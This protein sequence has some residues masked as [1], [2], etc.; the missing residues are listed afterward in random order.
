[1]T[2]KKLSGIA[3]SPGIVYGKVFLFDVQ[4]DNIV[5]THVAAAK[6]PFEIARLEEALIIT[7]REILDIQQRLSERLGVRHAEIFNA[8]LMVL[9]DRSLLEEVIKKLEKDQKNVEFVFNEVIQRYSEIFS[10]M[11]DEYLKER[12]TDIKDVARRVLH[13]LMGKKRQDLSH[14]TNEVIVIA[15]DLSPSDTALM[16]TDKIIGFATD[17]GSR[18]SHTAI[19]ART[20]EIPAVVGLHDISS[21]VKTGDWILLDGKRGIVVI[22]PSKATTKKYKQQRLSYIRFEKRLEELRDLPATTRDGKKIIV[23]A[24]I[25]LPDDVSS[26]ISHGACGVG[27]YRTEFLYMNRTDLPS[28]E[29]QYA[30]YNAVATKLYPHDVIIRTLDLGG[31]KFA[32]QLDVPREMNPFLGWRAIRFC[33]ERLDIFEVQLRAI[34]RA[35]VSSNV[36]LMYPMISTV[37][38]VIEA[39]K[40]LESVKNKM[41]SEGIAF[42]NDVEVGVMIEIPSAALTADI[43]AKYVDFFSIGTNDLIQYSLAVD[44]INEKVAYLYEPGNLGVLRLIKN[45]IECGHKE[46]ILV[47]MC[48]EMASEP[49]WIIVLLGMGLDEF[50]TSPSS[51]PEVKKVIRSVNFSEVKALSEK[52]L[53]L[54]STQKVHKKVVDYLKAILPEIVKT[55]DIATTAKRLHKA[56]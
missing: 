54:D 12:V 40:V 10:Q 21:K 27:L 3:A 8:H 49:E 45:V 30:A 22:N 2:E 55:R 14:L 13:N 37:S 44:R 5:S 6:L 33:L 41:R 9:E 34:L 1:M 36:K 35:S 11:E 26:V 48:G 25:E 31:D 17:A 42:N 43:I 50:S 46:N 52:V 19:M 32:S 15:S 18:T 39:N 20:L 56:L 29:E 51:V 24:N 23:A 16:H 7:R 28:E 4:E 38:E 47:G 53:T